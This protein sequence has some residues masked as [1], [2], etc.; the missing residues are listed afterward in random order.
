MMGGRV[1]GDRV[2]F[3]GEA[4]AAIVQGIAEIQSVIGQP[5]VVVGSLA[6]N[7]SREAR[8]TLSL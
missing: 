1:S 3:V 4:M 7:C 2:V 6:V 8:H 5:P